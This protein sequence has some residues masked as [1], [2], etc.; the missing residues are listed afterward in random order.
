[1][2]CLETKKNHRLDGN[3][4]AIL[5]LQEEHI[6]Y[7]CGFSFM[8]LM[9]DFTTLYDICVCITSTNLAFSSLLCVG[10]A[11]FIVSNLMPR[12]V[13][14]F[15]NHDSRFPCKIYCKVELRTMIYF[16]KY[17]SHYDLFIASTTCFLNNLLAIKTNNIL[18]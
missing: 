5:F 10:H 18:H 15:L 2:F 9:A 6:M 7:L 14:K 17:E 1:M 11:S 16:L 8:Y 13:K 3:K 4:I 12:A